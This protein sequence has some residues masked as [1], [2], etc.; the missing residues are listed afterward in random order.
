[1]SERSRNRIKED[2]KYSTKTHQGYVDY[3]L[4]QLKKAYTKKA[5][6]LEVIAS[7]SKSGD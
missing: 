2:I 7:V 4:P 6:D 5:I 3:D 1:M